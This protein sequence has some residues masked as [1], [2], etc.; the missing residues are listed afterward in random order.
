MADLWKTSIRRAGEE[1]ELT[2]SWDTE[3]FEEGAPTIAVQAVRRADGREETLEVSVALHED[4]EGRPAVALRAN[5]E[6]ILS[7]PL[8][9]LV[10]ADQFIELIPGWVY[11][12]GNPIVGCLLRA[13]ISATVGQ[14]LSCRR[15]TVEQPWFLPRARAIGGCFQANIG[16]VGAKAARRT[17]GA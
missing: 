16:K 11:G 7:V 14:I 8:S 5:N 15:H 13:G 6:T 1:Y 17:A 12:A 3:A 9:E 4:S 2:L 10:D